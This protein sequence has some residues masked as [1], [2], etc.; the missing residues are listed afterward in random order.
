MTIVVSG[1][2]HEDGKK[3]Q[4]RRRSMIPNLYIHEQLMF[5]YV[6]GRRHEIEQKHLLASLRK[7]HQSTKPCVSGDRGPFSRILRP[8]KRHAHQPV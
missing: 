4:T 1:A 5:E 3:C 7:L 6:K 2:T 8:L